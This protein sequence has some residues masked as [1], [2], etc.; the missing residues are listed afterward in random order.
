MP[1]PLP[2]TM[3]VISSVLLTWPMAHTVVLYD[4]TGALSAALNHSADT[5]SASAGKELSVLPKTLS[6]H[7][8]W[9]VPAIGPAAA[10]ALSA[11]NPS[12]YAAA[13]TGLI[14]GPRAWTATRA[15]VEEASMLMFSVQL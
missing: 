12:A 2:Y 3:S 4:S 5:L 9:R 14:D 7:W 1:G 6:L 10:P 13:A 15:W 11:T 8:P